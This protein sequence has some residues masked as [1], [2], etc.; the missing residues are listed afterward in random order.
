MNTLGKLYLVPTPIGNLKDITFRAVE[1]LKNA[2]YVLAEDTR[3]SK[4]LLQHFEITTPLR[5]YHTFNEHDISQNIIQDL[6]GG[7]NIA[8]I[9]D[10]GTPGISDPGYLL[11][12]QCIDA[13]IQ[14]ECLPGATAFV[15]ALVC[16]GKPLHHFLFIGFL[17][18]KKGRQSKLKEIAESPYTIVLYESPH[19]LLKT[20]EDLRSILGGEKQIS[21][22]R[23]ISKIYEE[24]RRDGISNLITHFT[25]TNPKGEFVIVI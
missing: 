19:K 22:S 15:P 1:V 13:G 24:H 9:S 20:L 3:T 25:T 8:L 21:I 2:D 17:P 11:A 5:A 12:K 23:E 6:K 18:V 4:P 14:I 7:K 16:S 10:A